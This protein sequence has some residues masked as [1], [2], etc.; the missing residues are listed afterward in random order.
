M[1]TGE[2]RGLPSAVASIVFCRLCCSRRSRRRRCG[3]G[4]RSPPAAGA[5]RT[6]LARVSSL[7]YRC[8]KALLLSPGRGQIHYYLPRPRLLP[9]RASRPPPALPRRLPAPSRLPPPRP[10][11]LRPLPAREWSEGRWRPVM[12]TRRHKERSKQGA[13][14]SPSGP[15][16]KPRPRGRGRRPPTGRRA[17]APGLC[18]WS[19]AAAA[20][21]AGRVP[22]SAARRPP[23]TGRR[24]AT[25]PRRG[26][27]GSACGARPAGKP[28]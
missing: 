14:R 1:F 19:A 5:P 16:I 25:A 13:R 23:D 15:F 24:A 27:A 7:A 12:G 17:A 2:D 11:L 26:H 21:L 20:V 10:P 22:G 28:A 6:A 4:R 18:E 9:S 3:S 8:I